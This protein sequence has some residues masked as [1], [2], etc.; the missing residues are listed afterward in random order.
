VNE[1]HLESVQ[2]TKNRLFLCL[3]VGGEEGGRDDDFVVIFIS[4]S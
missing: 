1:G 3:D 2:N 4:I